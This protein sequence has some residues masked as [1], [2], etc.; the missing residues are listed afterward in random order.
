MGVWAILAFFL[1]AAGGITIAFSII[2]KA[3]NLMR[4]IAI[5]SQDL[6]AGLV[7]GIAFV[8]TFVIALAAI[9]QPNHNVTGL[10]IL[11][12]TL[13]LD[14]FGVGIVGS[15]IW[16]YTLT[17]RND[18]HLVMSKES[19]ATWQAVQD[20]LQC[21]GYFNSTDLGTIGGFCTDAT[22]AANATP[23]VGPITEYADYT[24]N[25]IFSTVSICITPLTSLFIPTAQIYGFMAVILALF[26]AT[27][28]VIKKA[29][30]RS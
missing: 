19:A 4:N 12:W 2:W 5:S 11:N 30:K 16:F 26:L 29:Q 28:C 20:K 25:N 17:E 6:L 15:F 1:A 9:I 22:F 8:V 27:M 14:A 10:A 18:Y 3:P 23:C 13:L 24:L 7:L 21:C